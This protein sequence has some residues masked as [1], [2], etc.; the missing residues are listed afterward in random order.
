MKAV[1]DLIAAGRSLAYSEKS[2]GH[3]TLHWG[4]PAVTFA[5]SEG[6]PFRHTNYSE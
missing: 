3:R 2:V 4:I 1:A 6:V 5:L